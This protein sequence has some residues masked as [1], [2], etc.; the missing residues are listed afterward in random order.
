MAI[1][2]ATSLHSARRDRKRISHDPGPAETPWPLIPGSATR[3]RDARSSAWRRGRAATRR[4]P[5]CPTN[6]SAPEGA[7][8]RI[9]GGCCTRS[10][11]WSRTRSTSAS[12]PPTGASAIVGMSYRVQGESAER[13][14]PLSRDAAADP[15]VRM[16]RDRARR[17]QRAELLDRRA[18]RH[19]RRRAA[20]RGGRAARRRGDRFAR[21]RRRDAR[22]RA[23]RRALAAGS[24]PPT[25]AAGPTGAGGRSATAPRRLPARATRWRTAW[26]SRRRSPASTRDERRAAGAVLPRIAR[27]PAS[28]GRRSEPRIGILTPG[29]LQRD[30]FRAGLSRPLP[31][32]PA[33]RGR[34]PRGRATAA[35]MCAPSPA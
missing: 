35:S 30:L 29:P 9:G 34:R 31:R 33:G 3:R 18:R 27:R 21:F 23:A 32:V 15:R 6:S 13:S 28:R 26:S 19:L 24:T 5:A 20:G 22:R 2:A 11:I 1:P 7:A 25:S 10:P 4:C 14:W 16:A 12:P 8:G 17:D